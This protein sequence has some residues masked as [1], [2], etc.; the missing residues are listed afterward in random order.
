MIAFFIGVIS[1]VLAGMGLGGGVLLIPLLKEFFGVTQIEAQYISLLAYIPAGLTIIIASKNRDLLYKVVPL[2]P[3]GIVGAI[4]GGVV[5]RNINV[6]FLRKAYGVFLIIFGLVL[7]C[8][9]TLKGKKTS[10]KRFLT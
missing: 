9:N 10:K 1:Y 2:I 7:C 3:F 6:L 4:I 5:A 8:G